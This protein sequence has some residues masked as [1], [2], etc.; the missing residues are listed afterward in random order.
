MKRSV[1]L[2]VLPLFLIPTALGQTKPQGVSARQTRTPVKR[3]VSPSPP[4]NTTI[5]GGIVRICQGIAIP[6]GYTI[7]AYESS[8]SCP[9]G[10]YVLK[11]D[12]SESRFSDAAESSAPQTTSPTN[13]TE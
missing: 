2:F 4:P 11:R 9:H 6:K 7:V 1:A 13:V 3:K 5:Q 8:L 10:A 12:D